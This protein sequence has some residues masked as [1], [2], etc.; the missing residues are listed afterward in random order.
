M[1]IAASVAKPARRLAAA[2]LGLLALAGCI[3]PPVA[4]PGGTVAPIQEE[5]APAPLE[6]SDLTLIAQ[7]TGEESINQTLT[8][9]GIAG[10]DLGHTFDM[11]GRLYM[12]FGDTFGCCISG[13]GGPD[14]AGDWRRNAMAFIDD[15]D[16]S[17]GLTFAG[18]VADEEGQAKQLIPPG[19]DD[20]TLIPTNGIAQDGR[21]VLHYMAVR[22]WGTPG[23]WELNSSGL[24]YSD[25]E[26]QTW[27]KESAA[28]W[29]GDSNF[30]Q[31][32]FAR[33]GGYV[34]LFGIPGGRF[35]G[36]QLARVAE[37]S[38][39]DLGDYRYFSGATAGEA[40]WSEDAAEATTIVEAPVG[41]LSV[42]W[43][44]HLGRWIMTY[45]DEGKAALVIRSA[46]ALWGPWSEESI[47]VSGSDYPQLYGAYM[48][49]W[50]TENGGES[51]YFTMS[52][53]RPYNVFLMRAR[54][55]PGE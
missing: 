21:M 7:L 19:R 3:T 54:L 39:L 22:R 24:T 20:V 34:Y 44:E 5:D 29:P 45:L 33:Q 16:P 40:Q 38:L 23:R 55:A 12:V 42:I 9:Y 53:W 43:N 47:L 13:N 36:V 10:T 49:P 1:G 11:D 17:D 8:R 18:M 46:A 37:E 15:A 2:A 48:H 27:I 25:D 26:G 30:G 4:P 35:G 28:V 41:E 6:V 31:V 50:L 32:A 51:I 14:G 52:L